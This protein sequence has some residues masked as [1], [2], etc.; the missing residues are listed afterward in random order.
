MIF[1]YLPVNPCRRICPGGEDCCLNGQ[2]PHDLHICDD[3]S[4]RCHSRERYMQD[5]KAYLVRVRHD[6]P[7]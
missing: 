2:V 3:P 5:R 4:C 7:R 1:R 6:S